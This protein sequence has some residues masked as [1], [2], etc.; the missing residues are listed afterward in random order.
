M[1]AAEKGFEGTPFEKV[2]KQLK[3]VTGTPM[4]RSEALKILNYEETLAK[5]K[6]DPKDVMQV[7]ECV[8]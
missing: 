2:A 6:M 7:L 4:S 8:N 3:T 5:E 1:V